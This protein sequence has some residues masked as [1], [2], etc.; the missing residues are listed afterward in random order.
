MRFFMEAI[1]TLLSFVFTLLIF[2]YLLGDNGLFRLAV[3]VFIGVAAA[4]VTIATFT[5]VFIPLLSAL[6]S[7]EDLLSLVLL[8]VPLL[9]V[10]PLLFRGLP[11]RSIALGF[12]IAVGAA[13]ALIGA[14]TG[15]IFPI[16]LAMGRSTG[17][18]NLFEVVLVFV[19]VVTS[20]IYF[21]YGGRRRADGTVVKGTIAAWLGSI[22]EI[23]IVITLGALYAGAIL[24]SLT[25][26][27]ERVSMLVGGM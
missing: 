12:L 5:S 10:V 24:T 3:Y 9:L 6:S 26:L 17:D 14:L 23:F 4:F 16:V 15:T 25:I 22:G 20:L 19:G 27:S 7:K 21:Q 11:G 18:Q 13:V 2:S 1:G 8:F